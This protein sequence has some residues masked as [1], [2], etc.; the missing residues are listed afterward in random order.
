MKDLFS[1]LVGILVM[2]P[3][4]AQTVTLRFDGSA[5]SNNN[6][7]TVRNYVADVDGRKYYPSDADVAPNASSRQFVINDL[8]IGSHKLA[9]Y[10]ADNNSAINNTNLADPIYSNSFQ[11]RSGYDMV[12]S[13][14]KNGQVSFSEKRMNQ[15]TVSKGKAPMTDA[16][17]EKQLKT[18]NAK[19]SQTSKYNAVKASIN[20]KSNYFTTEQIGQL[21]MP[22]T[23]EAKRLELAKL[24]Y[25]KITDPNNFGDV[26]DLFQTKANKDNIDQFIRSK[27][28]EIAT[29]ANV[30]TSRPA[31]STQQFNQL[32]RKMKNQYDESGRIGVLRDA[33]TTSTNYFT[34]AQLRQLLVLISNETERLTLAK[35]SYA[36]VSDE[37][38][39][40]SLATI[41]NTQSNRDEFN[42]YI[43]YG[44]TTS[45][46][47][48]TITATPMS[49][50]D[51]TK[52]QMKAR[53]HFR[54]SSTVKEINTAFSDTK[55]Y[56]TVEQV[57]SLLSMVSAETDRLTLAKL[58]YHRVVDPA[59][60][61]QLYDL[62][63]QQASKDALD[64]YI[65][66]TVLK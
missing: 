5:N 12:I 52:L 58:S 4:S 28:P 32:Q 20:S 10:E 3:V 8:T 49:D 57:R 62:F 21:L 36:R 60:F 9:V 23:S 22:I 38:N 44:G 13:I 61:M 29:S 51:F 16:E 39:F 41:F 11:L 37:T 26:S 17:F 35:Q 6:N 55:N 45:S 25:P 14:R 7:N 53:L 48:Q 56:F 42:N 64:N 19:W 27:N 63:T 50:G 47:S 30:N 54:Q 24:S 2:I 46:S 66:S 65:K 43:R 40:S 1:V 18:V 34:T 59:N 15:N 31:M 33:L